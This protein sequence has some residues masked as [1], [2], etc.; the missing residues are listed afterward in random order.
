MT[1]YILFNHCFPTHSCG[2]KMTEHIS[3]TSLSL[4][5]CYLLNFVY[6][7]VQFL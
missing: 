3:P 6:F 4:V 1:Y 7:P 5:I 2:K